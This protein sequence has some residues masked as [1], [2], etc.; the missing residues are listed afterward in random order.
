[1]WHLWDGAE[2]AHKRP[3]LQEKGVT[4]D[5][6][7]FLFR[8]ENIIA[9]LGTSFRVPLSCNVQTSNPSNTA[10]VRRVAAAEVHVRADGLVVT[11]TN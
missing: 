2:D 3:F 1:M 9:F 4:R 8:G 5:R 10:P 6:L 11:P 7:T